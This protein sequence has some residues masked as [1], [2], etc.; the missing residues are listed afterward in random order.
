MN[1]PISV[2]KTTFAK[3]CSSGRITQLDYLSDRIRFDCDSVGVECVQSGLL[4][5]SDEATS[6]ERRLVHTSSKNK[7]GVPWLMGHQLRIDFAS[8]KVF[9]Q[10]RQETAVAIGNEEPSAIRR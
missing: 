1:Q 2:E 10:I 3:L 5:Q 6:E 4:W 7:V 9:A 8:G